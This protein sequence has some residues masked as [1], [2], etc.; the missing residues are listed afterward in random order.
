MSTT[1]PTTEKMSPTNSWHTFAQNFARLLEDTEGH[2]LIITVGR[3]PLVK[4]FKAHS[5][6]LRAH[7]PYFH[8]AL[9]KEWART[10]DG[11]I[12]FYKPNVSPSVFK[13][14][15]KYLYTGIIDVENKEGE[16]LLSLLTAADE[17]ILPELVFEIQE[18]LISI[19]STW[20]Q[21]NFYH[22]LDFVFTNDNYSTL[23]TYCLDAICADP[24]MLLNSDY[25]YCLDSKVLRSLLMRD[26]LAIEEVDLWN[27]L[28]KWAFVQHPPSI[29]ATDSEDP[30]KWPP[31]YF[32]V[33]KKSV[34]E[35]IPFIRFTAMTPEQ[36]REEEPNPFAPRLKPMDSNLIAYKHAA[37]ISSWIDRREETPYSHTEIPYDF[38]LLMR[39]SKDGYTQQ[40]LQKQCGGQAK[41]VMI[42]KIKSTE[43]IFGMYTSGVWNNNTSS[44]S[45]KTHDSFMF[46]FGEGRDTRKPVVSR[47]RAAGYEL[48][49]NRGRQ[50]GMEELEIFKITQKAMFM[51]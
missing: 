43:E 40:A 11:Q 9:S 26:D 4:S 20:I 37:L 25:F 6:I 19:Q 46:S 32:A 44:A 42:M 48:A 1:P 47:V 8:R 16:F 29:A 35:C 7:S 30:K 13:V 10:E 33:F 5:V 22:V 28:I 31:E 21:E 17:L 50:R 14:I 41:T 34:D 27:Y 23:Q 18:F 38:T 51:L 39:G 3:E 36:F 2:D 15:L 12:V 24:H 45:S 49:L